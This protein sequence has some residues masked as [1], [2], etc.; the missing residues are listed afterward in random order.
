MNLTLNIYES[1]SKHLRDLGKTDE[2]DESV[3]SWWA[4]IL[5]MHHMMTYTDTSYYLYQS[6]A[7]W[8]PP[9]ADLA[10]VSLNKKN[11]TMNQEQH[12]CSD[13]RLQSF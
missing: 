5:D 6:I 9:G 4:K 10:A 12:R 3:V 8:I 1:H 11:I 7:G 13:I 2:F